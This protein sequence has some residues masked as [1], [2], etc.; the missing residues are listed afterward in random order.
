MATTIGS[1]GL[2]TIPEEGSYHASSYWGGERQIQSQ[3]S[4]T[5]SNTSS[6]SNA[7][8]TIRKLVKK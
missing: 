1:D 2:E 7:W 6:T 4:V 8:S 5:S 3:T